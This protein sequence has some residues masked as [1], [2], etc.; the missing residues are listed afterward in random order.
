MKKQ[1]ILK[2]SKDYN[3]IIKKR[4]GINSN[5]FIINVE[6]NNENITKF[7]ITFT[8]NISKAVIRNKLKR[9]IKSIIDNNQYIFKNNTTYVIIAKKTTLNLK[10]Y[11]LEKELVNLFLKIKGEKYEK[12]QENK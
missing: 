10:Y 6:Q 7:G 5:Y 9:R 2:K 4:K 11:E 1:N 3:R 12:D 8:K